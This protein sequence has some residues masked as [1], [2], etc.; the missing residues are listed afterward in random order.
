M[1]FCREKM[2]ERS[3]LFFPEEK[4]TPGTSKPSQAS[5]L[6]SLKSLA[7]RPSLKKHYLLNRMIIIVVARIHP[8]IQFR[9]SRR[10]SI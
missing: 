2:S 1:F 5:R 4:Y 7:L 8:R 10:L 6:K 3:E 9:R